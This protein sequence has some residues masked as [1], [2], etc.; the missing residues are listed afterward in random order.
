E[1]RRLRAKRRSNAFAMPQFNHVSW[2]DSNQQRRV[3]HA[4]FDDPLCSH[5]NDDYYNYNYPLDQLSD[6]NGDYSD[7]VDEHVSL[8]PRR[9]HRLVRQRNNSVHRIR[10][11]G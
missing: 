1:E 5:D 8:L 10:V 11:F 3:H 6:D 7:T 9:S 4:T 2:R